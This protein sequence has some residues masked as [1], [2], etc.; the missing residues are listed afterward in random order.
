MLIMMD[1]W[2]ELGVNWISLLLLAAWRTLPLFTIALMVV[3]VMRRRLSPALHAV[4]WSLVIARLL[5]PVSI[6]SPVSMHA[7]I[8]SMMNVSQEPQS[9]YYYESSVEQFFGSTNKVRDNEV[10]DLAPQ[11]MLAT[12]SSSS[13]DLVDLLTWA[14]IMASIAMLTRGGI[15]YYR[16]AR[17]LRNSHEITEQSFVDEMLRQCDQ[18]GVG[19]RPK[20]LEV[21]TLTSPAVFGFL[22]PAICLPIGLRSHLSAHELRWVLCH[23]LAHIKRHDTWTVTIAMIT[24]SLHWMNPLA[25][26]SVRKM[27]EAIEASADRVATRGLSQSEVSAYGELL[28]R[29]AMNG[30]SNRTQF[31][32]LGLL[33]FATGKHLKHRIESLTDTSYDRSY[34]S[35]VCG[36]SLVLAITTMG[37][38]DASHFEAVPEPRIS[39]PDTSLTQ[40][41]TSIIDLEEGDDLGTREARTYD[42]ST[43]QQ[44]IPKSLQMSDPLEQLVTWIALLQPYKEHLRL[45]GST[46]HAS[47][48]TKQHLR[49]SQLLDA[50]KDGEPQQISLEVR[51]MQTN[52]DAAS[53]LPWLENKIDD[54]HIDGTGPAM[55]ATI[56]E[57]Q[58]IELI[59]NVQ[60]DRDGNILFAPKVTLYNSQTGMI[61]DEVQRPFVTQIKS[62]QGVAEMEPIISMIHEGFRVSLTPVMTGDDSLNLEFSL[63]ASKVDQVSLANLPLRQSSRDEVGVTVEVP[64]MLVRKVNSTVSLLEGQS[65]AVAIPHHFTRDK[66][67]NSNR[68]SV[69]TLTPRILNLNEN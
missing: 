15:A 30:G 53:S 8:D 38:T 35:K 22:R 3:L 12:E 32:A 54:L 59:H 28:L 18:V 60:S 4:L 24:R 68:I 9:S 10:R 66:G 31:A 23:E 21:E 19:R 1:R 17:L 26:F 61:S 45:E 64:Q 49:V 7:W 6:S 20:V 65:I 57:D 37:L 41:N 43:I 44:S 27:K 69:V 47:L 25:W 13:I 39:I 55:A 63:R 67:S 14:I 34:A 16:F 40:S 46:L 48:T 62:M 33:P 2:L 56:S 42:V 50:W 51:F 58:L 11:P 5:L 36:L 52:I 29:L